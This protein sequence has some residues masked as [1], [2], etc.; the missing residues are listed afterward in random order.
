MHQD[1]VDRFLFHCQYERN[2]SKNTIEAYRS[3]LLRY[4]EFAEGQATIP[5]LSVSNLQAFLAD[6]VANM[7]LAEATVRRR[8]A[9]LR[10]FSKFLSET[11]GA[12]DPF[13]DWSP[14][15]K[16]PKRLPRAVAVKT[17]KRL[18]VR[19]VSISSIDAET[20]F[21]VL[22]LSSTG[23][24]V[25]ELCSVRL[26][27]LAADGSRI[28]VSGKG[29]K[30]RIVYVGNSS[31][32]Q[33]LSR[34]REE[35][36]ARSG[37]D[38]ATAPLLLNSRGDE[39]KPQ[40]LRRRLHQL[41]AR[42]GIELCITPHSLRHTAATLLIEGGIDIRFVQR[43]LGHASI[44]TTELYTHVSDDALE[45]AMSRGDTIARFIN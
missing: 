5:L 8:M 4:I 13:L 29:A 30:D 43:Q 40:T 3:D 12:Q 10:S 21:C 26:S 44:A 39:L 17:L 6:M 16:R 23:L 28:H 31:L 34:K 36:A 20:I 45:R 37:A 42:R 33:Q 7:G 2:Y 9:S 11:S 27:D 38:W 41:R 18:T 22:V 14:R 35:A 24:R 32:R 25:S 1:Q 15:L 19:D